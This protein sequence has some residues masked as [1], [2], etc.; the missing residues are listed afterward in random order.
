MIYSFTHNPPILSSKLFAD[1]SALVLCP[2]IFDLQMNDANAC[3]R[4]LGQVKEMM[5]PIHI[6]AQ[7]IMVKKFSLSHS[8]CLLFL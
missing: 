8:V 1:E 5:Y 7:L 2:S 6:I 3:L 4:K